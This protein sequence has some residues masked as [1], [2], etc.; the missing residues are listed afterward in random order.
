MITEPIWDAEHLPSLTS[1]LLQHKWTC[2]FTGI[3]MRLA[4]LEWNTT[5]SSLPTWCSL[6]L[7]SPSSLLAMERLA[8]TSSPPPLSPSV[9]HSIDTSTVVCVWEGVHQWVN[10]SETKCVSVCVRCVGAVTLHSTVI[11]ARPFP[12]AEFVGASWGE[13]TPL[14]HMRLTPLPYYKRKYVGWRTQQEC[15]HHTPLVYQ[16]SVCRQALLER[17]TTAQT[18]TL[19]ILSW[20]G[21]PKRNYKEKWDCVFFPDEAAKRATQE[22][23]ETAVGW[24]VKWSENCALFCHQP[25]QPQHHTKN[26]PG[27]S[28]YCLLV[29]LTQ[30]STGFF[31][32][33]NPCQIF[34][35]LCTFGCVESTTHTKEHIL[36]V[37]KNFKMHQ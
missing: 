4:Y 37:R 23:R 20:R 31:L 30:S 14:C 29:Q 9:G 7:L 28:W 21:C 13:Y 17:R 15:T 3:P 1:A 34:Q 25:Q 16:K 12:G 36:F 2:L 27:W 35:T 19:P 5:T 8:C 11:V 18:I 6:L 32:R 24:V 22:K 26:E 10:T 33:E